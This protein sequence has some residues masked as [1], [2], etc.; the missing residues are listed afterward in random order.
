[1][2]CQAE[3]GGCSGRLQWS[4]AWPLDCMGGLLS[5]PEP[6]TMRTLFKQIAL[7]GVMH[8]KSLVSHLGT[9]LELNNISQIK[10]KTEICL[11]QSFPGSM[12]SFL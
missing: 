2:F 6:L 12:A 5:D 7:R 11:S 9:L 1:M 10:G 4:V 8:D 3:G